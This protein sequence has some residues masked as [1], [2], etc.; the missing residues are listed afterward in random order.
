MANVDPPNRPEWSRH[1]LTAWL[2]LGVAL[3]VGGWLMW[4][5]HHTI[6]LDSPRLWEL[7]RTDRVFDVA[8]LDFALTAAWAALVW[9]ERADWRDWRAWVA[10]GLF[11]VVPSLG[12]VALILVTRRR[13]SVKPLKV[14]DDFSQ[15]SP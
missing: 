11:C 4:E 5:I 2:I 12:I 8:M 14:R 1:P 9:I 10:F 3:P 13:E 15:T 7:L 6:G